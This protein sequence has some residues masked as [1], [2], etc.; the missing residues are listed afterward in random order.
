MLS[1]ILRGASSVIEPVTFLSGIRIENQ[2]S[3]DTRTLTLSSGFDVGDL[4]V[5]MIANRGISVTP[6]TLSGYTSIVAQSAGTGDN[7]RRF[8]VQRKIATG[9][10]ETITW[11]GAYGYLIA[12]R[13]FTRIG[14][15]G[16]NSGT[17][18]GFS[19]P[20][21]NLTS[22]DTSSSGF[23][24]AGSYATGNF[25]ASSPYTQLSGVGV[26]IPRN[27]SAS[28]TSRTLFTTPLS[29]FVLNYAIEIL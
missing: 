23:I 4:L 11:N 21:P 29:L 2:D 16:T 22:L 3:N 1:T 20:L 5:A 18:S 10:S 9:T 14:R 26:Q 6:T 15:T 25:T 24:L 27:T 28:L 19:Q 12:F 8:R 17:T 7:E 13:N